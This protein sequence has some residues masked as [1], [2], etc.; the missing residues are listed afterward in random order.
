MAPRLFGALGCTCFLVLRGWAAFG[1]EGQSSFVRGDVDESG[2]LCVTDA[3]RI[4]RYLF[5]ENGQ[6]VV[7]QCEDA[8]DANDDGGVNLTDAVFIL[9]AV[10]RGGPQPPE[11]SASCGPDPTEDGIG[12]SSNGL[13]TPGFFGVD[14]EFDC[15]V[16]VVD[17]S[18][19]MVDLP[20]L[21][22]E[23]AKREVVRAL[24]QL[25]EGSEFGIVFF[26][27]WVLLFPEGG[28]PASVS[29]GTVN[30]AWFFVQTTEGGMWTCPEG[31]L[32]A[33]IS[34]ARRASG[35]RKLIAFL[36]DGGGTCDGADEAAYLS[37]TVRVVT[38]YN[39]GEVRIHT[40]GIAVPESGP[41]ESF[42]KD[43]AA[44]NGGTYTAVSTGKNL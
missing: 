11:P 8:A 26:D 22:L 24:R 31:G 37:E 25:P 34:M 21:R 5:A 12:C 14:L 36:S 38:D 43:L 2:Y 19:T 6:P 16:F 27:W 29:P 40:F 3:L 42:L 41:G 30:E 7:L 35:R 18:T 33:A 23:T 13:C 9:N 20:F 15:I 17:R 44:A 4:L 32:I 39:Q 1:A 28:F 10:F